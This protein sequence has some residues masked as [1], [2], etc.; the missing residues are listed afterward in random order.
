ME[1]ARQIQHL[2]KCAVLIVLSLDLY[3]VGIAVPYELFLD[4]KKQCPVIDEGFYD[5]SDIK[6]CE[7]GD[8][9]LD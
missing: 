6:V 7:D 1:A 3:G 4:K 5:D 2:K 9:N 8:K